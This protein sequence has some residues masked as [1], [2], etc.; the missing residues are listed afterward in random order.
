M[1]TLVHKIKEIS[2][3]QK[4]E[5][6]G[7]TIS[8]VNQNIFTV[9]KFGEVLFEGNQVLVASYVSKN[10][11]DTLNS[12]SQNEIEALAEITGKDKKSILLDIE[13]SRVTTELYRERLVSGDKRKCI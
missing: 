4:E 9:S 5:L 12:F 6:N 8:K 7:Y 10:R 2:G 13:D 3:D 11:Q 1:K